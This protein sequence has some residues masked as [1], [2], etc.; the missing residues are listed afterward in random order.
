[1]SRDQPYLGSRKPRGWGGGRG[2]DNREPEGHRTWGAECRLDEHPGTDGTLADGLTPWGVMGRL[3]G[4]CGLMGPMAGRARGLGPCGLEYRRPEVHDGQVHHLLQD[5]VLVQRDQVRLVVHA[6]ARLEGHVRKVQQASDGKMIFL[7]GVGYLVAGLAQIVL[8]L[9]VDHS[10]HPLAELSGTS[11][12]F[13]LLLGVRKADVSDLHGD[14]LELQLFWGRRLL[15]DVFEACELPNDGSQHPPIFHVR[16]AIAFHSTRP[17][18]GRLCSGSCHGP[19]CAA[20]R[21]V[22]LVPPI[23]ALLL[24]VVVAAPFLAALSALVFT[25]AL[26]HARLR[27]HRPCQEKPRSVRVGCFVVE[28]VAVFDRGPHLQFCHVQCVSVRILHVLQALGLLHCFRARDAC[29]T[30]L[31]R[32]PIRAVDDPNVIDLVVRERH[33]PALHIAPLV[34]PRGR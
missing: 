8:E 10:L 16:C 9:I 27:F 12:P 7:A 25:I 5:A 30:V 31:H 13:W 26:W 28:A 19:L 14:R 18:W 32:F 24:C 23:I 29:K 22:A 1:M 17:G 21:A 2:R 6:V 20:S 33:R 34:Y 4:G 3:L 11:R 15:D